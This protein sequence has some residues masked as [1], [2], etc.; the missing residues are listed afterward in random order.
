M[1]SLVT[2]YILY[3]IN[4]AL[5]RRTFLIHSIHSDCTHFVKCYLTTVNVFYILAP[6]YINNY[7]NT[8]TSKYYTSDVLKGLFSIFPY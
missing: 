1:C 5:V 8:H 2:D 3:L 7:L 6:N 4:A